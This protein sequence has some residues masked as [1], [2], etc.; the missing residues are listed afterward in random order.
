MTANLDTHIEDVVNIFE[1]EGIDFAALVGHSY[2]GIVITGVY[3]GVVSMGNAL[4]GHD[5]RPEPS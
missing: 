2:G 4:G 5:T 1:I 3:S